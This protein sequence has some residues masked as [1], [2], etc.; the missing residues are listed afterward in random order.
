M[1]KSA[2]RR[3]RLANKNK[4]E[5][6]SE[7]FMI[8]KL[9]WKFWELKREEKNAKNDDDGEKEEEVVLRN[10]I[11]INLRSMFREINFKLY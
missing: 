11:V 3:K 1:M 4:K 10:R 5:K 8:I 6:I 2:F 7:N 9:N